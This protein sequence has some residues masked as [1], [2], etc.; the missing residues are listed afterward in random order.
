MGIQKIN[1]HVFAVGVINPLLRKFDIVMETK[2]GTSYNAYLVKDEKIALVETVHEKFFDEYLENIAQI[3]DVKK[4][5]YIIMNHN[6]PDHSGSIRKL[7]ELN[8]DIT[9]ITSPGGKRFVEQI[10]NRTFNSL[11]VKDGDTVSLGETELRFINAPFLHW[12]DSM[13]TYLEAE[14]T[15]FT[16][17]FLGAHY[18]E[19]R[20]FNTYS[21]SE[22]YADAFRYYYDCIFGPFKPYVLDGLKKLEGLEISAICPS[23]GAV[24]VE[25]FD[26]YISKYRE[27]STPAEKTEKTLF[28]PFASCYGY[29]R[30]LAHAIAEKAEADGFKAELYD[31]SE[32][33]AGAAAA[34]FTQADA[35]IVASCTINQDA[36]PV[37]W[38]MLEGVCPDS[39]QG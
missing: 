19:T 32:Q 20:Y 14:K 36:P 1:D 38:K 28:I 9:V 25:N 29:S 8:P 17:D 12:P 26:E 5:D 23:H 31:V 34:H 13:F 24:I 35:V 11:V 21:D 2:F 33:D 27:W 16:C 3:T 18:C 6:E 37:V 15:V 22:K 10:V 7:L 39:L 4:I 30:M